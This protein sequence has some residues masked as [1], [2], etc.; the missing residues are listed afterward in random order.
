[1]RKL[2]LIL[3]LTPLFLSAQDYEKQFLK[4]ESFSMLES[5]T[6]NTDFF[7]DFYTGQYLD[8][9]QKHTT[10]DELNKK[11][12]LGYYTI[13]SLQYGYIKPDK[14]I[15]PYFEASYQKILGL[16]FS[17]NLFELAFI[18]NERF[19]GQNINLQPLQMQMHEFSTIQGGIVYKLSDNINIHATVG[20]AFGLG[21]QNIDTWKLNMF[22]SEITDSIALD[23]NLLY[24]RTTS[25]PIING[26]GVSGAIGASGMLSGID[27]SI[28]I[29]NIGML[30]Y[31]AKSISTT[32][33]SIIEFT[34]FELNELSD[35]SNSID[36]ELTR[37]EN[38]FL[39]NGDT[40]SIQC[41]LPLRASINLHKDFDF[42]ELNFKAFYLN[43]PGFIPYFEL[44]PSKTIYKSIALCMP[45]KYGGF[46]AFNFGLGIEGKLY[47]DY[48]FKIFTPALLSAFDVNEAFSYGIFASVF[49]NFTN[50]ESSF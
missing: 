3:F 38:A 33:D 30:W 8:S 13:N 35:I 15:G 1:M 7:I 17:N 31:D 24:Q 42:L 22:T 18:G 39:L 34:G 28:N 47:K 44:T 12:D 37:L 27:W 36:S 6:L 45:F 9:T 14:K 19:S 49:I 46:G 5:R 32:K 41:N 50:N 11:N 20:P 40:A 10:L 21:Y 48:Y 2:F 4:L 23:Y 25:Y 26:Y 43:S 16:E 29:S